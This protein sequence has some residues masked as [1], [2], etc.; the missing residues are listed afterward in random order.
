MSS[1]TIYNVYNTHF[2][3]P[4]YGSVS[5]GGGDT[6]SSTDQNQDLTYR[7][8][9]LAKV[10]QLIEGV[11]AKSLH[12][13]TA[14]N[15]ERKIIPNAVN[16]PWSNIIPES[17]KS[18]RLASVPIDY[19]IT[20]IYEHG[21]QA[22]LI[23]GEPGS[24]KTTALLEI[25][26]QAHL[27]ALEYP[28]RP[29]P[30]YLN[31]SY[32]R[33]NTDSFLDWLVVQ[34]E[35]QYQ[36]PPDVSQP[37][38]AQK[39]VF[40]WLLDGLDEVEPEYQKSCVMAINEFRTKYG[41]YMVISSRN[42]AY[43]AL[44]PLQL[45]LEEAIQFQPLN[46]TQIDLYLTTVIPELTILREHLEQYPLLRELAQNPLMLYVMVVAY[47]GEDL[48]NLQQFDS[49]DELG[50]FLFQQYTEQMFSR[51]RPDPKSFSKEKTIEALAWLAKKMS[52]QPQSDFWLE[53]MQPSWLK[54]SRQRWWYA[55]ISRITT[56][57]VL[58]LIWGGP[59]MAL[60]LGL[61]SGTGIGAIVGYRFAHP[62][63]HVQKLTFARRRS[64]LIMA[65]VG[66]LTS[67]IVAGLITGGIIFL[68]LQL[69]SE[70]K[71]SFQHGVV[72]II[73]WGFVLFVVRGVIY[74]L[75]FGGPDRGQDIRADI[76]TRENLVWSLDGALG[77][78]RAGIT[79]GLFVSSLI[80]IGVA[81]AASFL[82]E[83]VVPVIVCISI[84][85]VAELT[86]GLFGGLIGG[87][88]GKKLKIEDSFPGKALQDT[89]KNAAKAG[90]AVGVI[91]GITISMIVASLIVV[92]FGLMVDQWLLG[93]LVASPV[94]I[95]MGITMGRT[96]GGFVALWYGGIDL[97]QHHT[98][99]LLLWL[100]GELPAYRYVNFLD[101]ATERILLKKVGGK[102]SFHHRLLQEYFATCYPP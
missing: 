101:Y 71:L 30:V 82:S 1:P 9:L 86:Y 4:V 48:R 79:T 38:I 20:D 22:L 51:V 81:I 85:L 23:L 31:L 87:L 75:I 7:R 97:V 28:T 33:T 5:T 84:F 45:E 99:R 56:S 46:L 2:H 21:N 66:G 6:P 17:H 69:A 37:W 47:Q 92:V 88:H 90:V 60:L 54:T 80:S 40:L 77:G 24:G 72:I 62:S 78:F 65:L 91:S 41:R 32:W 50:R 11:L 100:D 63:P 44:H 36:V 70:G 26:Y 25:A 74:G 73:F 67:G 29:I 13:A 52:D 68:L 12:N 10:Y 16:Y 34:M 61:L 95:M 64:F 43:Y 93:I 58:E 8:A 53:D 98:L 94:G 39:E 59:V 3:G 76:Q 19:R 83:G 18:H 89:L 14:I 49:V 42:Q 15:L 27:L 57:I 55:L 96:I 102:Y 35:K